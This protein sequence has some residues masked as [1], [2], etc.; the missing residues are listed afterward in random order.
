M[1]TVRGNG[2]FGAMECRF[3]EVVVPAQSLGEIDGVREV[4]L[5]RTGAFSKNV[6]GLTVWRCSLTLSRPVLKAQMFSA[7]EARI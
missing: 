3:G 6:S 2:F 5:S 4:C 7:L 1:V